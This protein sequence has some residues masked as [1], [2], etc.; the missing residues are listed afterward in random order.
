[1]AILRNY[2][3]Y[4]TPIVATI[5][6]TGL[7]NGSG[8]TMVTIMNDT[9]TGLYT[10]YVGIITLRTTTGTHGADKCCYA[11][12][13][14]GTGTAYDYPGTNGDVALTITGDTGLNTR[15]PFVIN[16]GTSV[17]GLMSKTKV[18][19]VGQAFGGN[20]PP[21]FGVII[22]NQ[23]GVLLDS[24]AANHSVSFVPVYNYAT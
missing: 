2:V 6:L 14:G 1:M 13:Y 17:T 3:T 4:G 8:R 24:T 20:I 12:L 16:F 19:F 23:T 7:A 11:H 10:D 21:Q 18:F 15:G 9:A 22:E 5:T